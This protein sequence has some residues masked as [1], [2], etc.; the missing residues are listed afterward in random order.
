MKPEHG[1][2]SNVISFTP[3][4]VLC[5]TV[6]ARKCCHDS[7]QQSDYIHIWQQNG[8]PEVK[9]RP[10]WQAKIASALQTSPLIDFAFFSYIKISGKWSLSDRNPHLTAR[11][12]S[13]LAQ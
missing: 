6:K 13:F 11:S 8:Q 3:M 4:F 1:H 10:M 12:V 7:V 5:R 2:R 9:V